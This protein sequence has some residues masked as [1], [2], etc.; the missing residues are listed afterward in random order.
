M[1]EINAMDFEREVLNGGKV[2]LDFYSTECPPCEALAPKFEYVSA[3]YSSRI[4][5]LKI[6]RQGNRELA[7][8]LGVTSSPTVLFFDKG[9]QV[10]DLISGGIKKSQLMENLDGMLS[11]EE[12]KVIHSHQKPTVSEYEVLILGGGPA[13]LTAGMYLG[14]A[15]VSTVL[16]DPALT[17]GYMGITHQVSNYP[18]FPEPQPGYMLAH[19]M[20]EQAKHS[21]IDMKLAVD[22]TSVDLIKKEM[23]IDELETIRFKKIILAT[24]TTPNSM[25]VPGQDEFKGKGLSYCA[26]CDAK[27]YEGKEVVVIGGGNSAVEEALFIAKFASKITMVHQFDALT[28]NRTA[29]DLLKANPIISVKYESEPRALL[30]RDGK[31]ITLIEHLPTKKTTELESDGVFVFIGFRPNLS[32][33]DAALLSLDAWGYILVDEDGRTNLPDVYA[34]GDIVSKKYR[35]ITTAVSDGTV[36][37]IDVSRELEA[38]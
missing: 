8:K 12:V 27:Y 4:K 6:Y 9:E 37:A 20:S 10:A 22:V 28:A 34:A 23:I 30:K 32:M 13:G 38:A 35:Q 26:T 33:L 16:V 2:V 36:A 3:L 15:K 19:Y 18:G 1:K 5:F 29:I 24:G 25:N 14:Q 21:G 17:G 31:M 11:P 7:Q